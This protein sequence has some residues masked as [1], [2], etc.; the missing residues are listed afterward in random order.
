MNK[1]YLAILKKHYVFS[2][3]LMFLLCIITSL[4]AIL[5]IVNV[6]ELIN[7][8]QQ[9][10]DVVINYFI[11][12]IILFVI[13]IVA[14]NISLCFKNIYSA[15]FSENLRNGL[16]KK[17]CLMPYTDIERFQDGDVLSIIN[18][19]AHNMSVWLEN[20]Y[21]LG[22]LPVKIGVAL[23]FCFLYSWQISAIM[24]PI[25]PLAMLVP[26]LMSKKLYN[27]EL[28]QKKLTGK[29]NVLFV[30]ILRFLH[31]IKSY[32]IQNDYIQ[33]NRNLMRQNNSVK[34]KLAKKNHFIYF[35]GTTLGHVGSAV[36]LLVGA[37]LIFNNKIMLG[38]LYSVILFG[39]VVGEAINILIELPSNYNSAKASLHR[40]NQILDIP[41]SIYIEE[42]AG[43]VK[44]D[45]LYAYELENISFGYDLF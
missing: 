40:I 30:N 25:A 20:L 31:I 32:N 34:Y 16:T 42:Q 43:K 35:F 26:M 13:S 24:I 36:I 7:S 23:F 17:I 27:L 14:E 29:L 39:G 12:I 38:D 22:H 19:D 3:I 15:R 18:N 44:A 37:Y 9:G 11:N 8:V 2:L 28:K 1:L 45:N 21:T 6:A 10:Y 4:A 33:Q 41:D 5:Q